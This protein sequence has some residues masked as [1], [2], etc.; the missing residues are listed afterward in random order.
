MDMYFPFYLSNVFSV[1]C[2][3]QGLEFGVR[4]S[5]NQWKTDFAAMRTGTKLMA[6]QVNNRRTT[7]GLDAER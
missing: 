6:T 1:F 3:S 2:S 5:F 7:K 4:F